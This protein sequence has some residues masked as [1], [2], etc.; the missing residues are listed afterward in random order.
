MFKIR[1]TDSQIEIPSIL[2]RD[3]A[4]PGAGGGGA[5]T[6]TEMAAEIPFKI[7]PSSV[8]FAGSVLVRLTSFISKIWSN[9]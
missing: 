8:R 3:G 4:G 5:G 2:M 1:E 9:K 7:F 6:S